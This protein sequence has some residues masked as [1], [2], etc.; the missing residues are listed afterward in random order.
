MAQWT[1][2]MKETESYVIAKAFVPHNYENDI[3]INIV[4]N[5]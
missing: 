4:K 5:K 3:A 2:S 1:W